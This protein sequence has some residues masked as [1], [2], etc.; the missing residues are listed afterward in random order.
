L[1]VLH[2]GTRQAFERISAFVRAAN[3]VGSQFPTESGEIQAK[4]K[5]SEENIAS[6]TLAHFKTE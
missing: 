1:I 2:I 3:N 6:G 4:E 5:K